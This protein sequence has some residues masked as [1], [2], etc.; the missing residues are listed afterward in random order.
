MGLQLEYKRF[1]KNL[2]RTGLETTSSSTKPFLYI[3]EH[4]STSFLIISLALTA[5]IH[6]WNPAG[7]PHIAA[8]EGASNKI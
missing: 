4:K 2:G 6:L 5:F 3:F 8:D 1:Y 7:F